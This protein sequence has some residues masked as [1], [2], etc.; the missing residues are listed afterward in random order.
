MS[1]FKVGDRVMVIATDEELQRISINP[2]Q[3]AQ[4]IHSITSVTEWECGL[5]DGYWYKEQHLELVKDEWLPYPENIPQE[6]YEEL[7]MVTIAKVRSG[8]VSHREL[9][10]MGFSPI[11]SDVN[12]HIIYGEWNAEDGELVLAF[13]SLPDK[14]MG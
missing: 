11:R 10:F 12:G 2:E 9:K 7:Y 4:G 8:K 13:Q 1:K 5:D 6:G 14:Y 3:K